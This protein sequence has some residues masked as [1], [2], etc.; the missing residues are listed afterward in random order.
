MAETEIKEYLVDGQHKA[1]NGIPPTSTVPLP[2]IGMV[3]SSARLM[4]EAEFT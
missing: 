3:V 4:V 2:T 1:L